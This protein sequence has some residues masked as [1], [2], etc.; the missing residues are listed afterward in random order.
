KR[1]RSV[2]VTPVMR[3]ET[4]KTVTSIKATTQL[5]N[6]AKLSLTVGQVCE[7]AS[8]FR[9]ELRKILVKPRASE[10]SRA[11]PKPTVNDPDYLNVTPEKPDIEMVNLLS[12]QELYQ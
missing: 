11:K 5:M 12:E 2:R 6:E 9:T 10:S 1:K 4:A 7:L 3:E 8:S